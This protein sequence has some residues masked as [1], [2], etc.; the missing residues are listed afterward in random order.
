MEVYAAMVDCMDQGIGRIVARAES[1][2]ASWTT[3]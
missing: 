2:R 1:S 3:R